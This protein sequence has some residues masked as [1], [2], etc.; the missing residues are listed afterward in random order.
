MAN[1]YVRTPNEFY[2]YSNE[3]PRT[4]IDGLNRYLQLKDININRWTTIFQAIMAGSAKEALEAAAA[5]GGELFVALANNNTVQIGIAEGANV[6]TIA[7]AHRETYNE[8][9]Q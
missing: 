6:A 9:Y 3:S 8:N 2:G 5:P 1:F 4:F 7:T